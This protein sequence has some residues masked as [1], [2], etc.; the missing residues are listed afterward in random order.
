VL[1]IL[2][3]AFLIGITYLKYRKAGRGTCTV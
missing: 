3:G 1:L 2:A